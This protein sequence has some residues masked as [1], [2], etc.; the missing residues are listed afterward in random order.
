MVV[1]VVIAG[2][3]SADE[4]CATCGKSEGQQV[5]SPTTQPKPDDLGI[6]LKSEALGE[7]IGTMQEWGFTAEDMR[8]IR[9]AKLRM[10]RLK[11]QLEDELQ[12]LAVAMY[13]KNDDPAAR[14]EAAKQAVEK[15]KRIE[16]QDKQLQDELV[17]AVGAA[18]DP[19]KMAGLILL[20]AV[21]GGRRTMCEVRPGVAGGAQDARPDLGKLGLRETL[22][23]PRWLWMGRIPLRQGRNH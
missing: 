23:P 5:S 21:G 15:C 20:G 18:D 17:R 3:A 13:S 6:V 8:A 1:V 16:Q 4:G 9:I 14:L 22:G 2:I 12:A 10:L 19:V 7:R 11:Q